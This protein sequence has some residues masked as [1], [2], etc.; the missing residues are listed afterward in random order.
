M[1]TAV[2]LTSTIQPGG[3]IEISNP[4]L[5]SGRAVDIIILFQQEPESVR[6]SVIDVLAE[7]PGQMAFQSV[8]EADTYLREE[9]DAWDR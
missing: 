4:Q 7:A 8:E 6:R 2:R 1:Q 3:R 9:R 5:P